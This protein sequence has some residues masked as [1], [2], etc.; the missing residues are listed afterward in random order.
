VSD[1][2][3]RIKRGILNHKIIQWPGTQTGIRLNLLSE[4]DSFDAITDA[5]LLF[6]AKKVPVL[7]HNVNAFENEKSV[8]L[9][10]RAIK[11]PDTNEPVASSITEFR[12]MMS[13]EDRELLIA[14]YN[15]LVVECSPSPTNMPAEEFDRMV[16]SLKKNALKTVGSISSILTLKRLALYL[17]EIANLPKDSGPIS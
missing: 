4:A 3:L 7:F 14:E 11:T 17:V 1:L 5:D 9:L 15:A 10:Y 6:Q 8:Q 16:E 12:R 2:L 13:N